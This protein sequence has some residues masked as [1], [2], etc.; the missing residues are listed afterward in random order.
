MGII[1]LI[2]ALVVAA[3]LASQPVAAATAMAHVAKAGMSASAPG[4]DCP[5]CNPAKPDTCSFKCCQ[6]QA[7]AVEALPIVKPS[8]ER[9]IE[10]EATSK[11][12]ATVRPDPPPP[13]A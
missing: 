6:M 3:S 2:W 10:E 8:P 9:Y 7:L 11:T 13:R 12:A 4:D 1:R 5:Y